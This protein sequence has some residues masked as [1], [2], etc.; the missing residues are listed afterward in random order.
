[1]DLALY[2][3]TDVAL[4]NGSVGGLLPTRQMAA[5]LLGTDGG[6]GLASANSAA[7]FILASQV[8]VTQP[9]TGPLP[10]LGGCGWLVDTS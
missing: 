2:G 7:S 4:A 3:K 8:Q 9:L 1:V 5:M 6:G 10:P